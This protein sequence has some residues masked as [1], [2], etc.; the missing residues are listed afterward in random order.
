MHR[1]W[2]LLLAVALAACKDAPKN[3]VPKTL[4]VEKVS[5]RLQ[6]LEEVVGLED[7][8]RPWAAAQAVD[9]VTVVGEPAQTPSLREIE[10]ESLDALRRTEAL[11]AFPAGFDVTEDTFWAAASAVR[12]A[13]TVALPWRVDVIGLLYAAEATPSI[14]T[15][16]DLDAWI[17]AHG[18]LV[19]EKGHLVQTLVPLVWSVGGDFVDSLRTL[20]VATD[21]AREALSFLERL[22]TEESCRPAAELESAFAAGQAAVTVGGLAR[23]ARLAA[24]P[25]SMEPFPPVESGRG[26]PA[27]WMRA[28][29]WVLPAGGPDAK[30]AA[31]LAWHLATDSTCVALL[32]PGHLPAYRRAAPVQDP[33]LAHVQ[34]LLPSARTSPELDTWPAVAEA[35]EAAAAAVVARRR[36]PGAALDEAAETVRSR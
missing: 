19:L 8:L 16:Q 1:P 26:Q 12:G 21:P 27:L 23:R 5:V 9:V 20:Q 22:V 7:A 4:P 30:L 6:L 10:L 3:E 29:A 35:L 24:Q 31:E 25:V 34:A 33:A 17:Q 18:P 11:R 15:W 28:K 14:S 36:S 13:E 32:G 2:I